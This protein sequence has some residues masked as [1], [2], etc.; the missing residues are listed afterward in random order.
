[1]ASNTWRKS[2][3]SGGQGGNCVEVKSDADVMVRDTKNQGCGP[4]L[5]FTP[6]AWRRVMATLKASD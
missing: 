1:M 3:Y 2:S 4:V 5:E 6:T